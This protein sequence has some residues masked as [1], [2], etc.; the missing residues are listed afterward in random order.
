LLPI[1]SK[2]KSLA[3]LLEQSPLSLSRNAAAKGPLNK[4]LRARLEKWAEAV[5]QL[6]SELSSWAAALIGGSPAE[7]APSLLH[8]VE[9][10]WLNT[11][12]SLYQQIYAPARHALL[13]ASGKESEPPY[14]GLEQPFYADYLRP[15]LEREQT[16]ESLI[17][18]LAARVRWLCRAESKGVRLQLFVAEA[19]YG[20]DDAALPRML[21]GSSQ[22]LEAYRKLCG[23]A[24]YYSARLEERKEIDPAQVGDFFE[25]QPAFLAF[26]SSRAQTTLAGRS[27]DKHYL[28]I[29]KLEWQKDLRQPQNLKPDFIQRGAASNPARA[30]TWLSMRHKIFLAGAEVYKRAEESYSFEPE[31]HIFFPEQRA[32]YAESRLNNRSTHNIEARQYLHPRFIR[33]LEFGE[34]VS[35]SGVEKRVTLADVFL[36]GWLCRLIESD[37]RMQRWRIPP[38]GKFEALEFESKQRSL[39]DAL[40]QFALEIP[41]ASHHTVA[42]PLAENNR[43]AY[44]A[45][46]AEAMRKKIETDRAAWSERLREVKENVIPQITQENDVRAKSLAIY[47]Q[48]L[49][50]EERRGGL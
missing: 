12:T 33:L 43:P 39:L 7:S 50:V 45:A 47:L 32:A 2:V 38:A 8:I 17:S 40:E 11:R 15:E 10:E 31:T 48:F 36:R 37:E 49:V 25:G 26:S 22:W 13:E 9:S 1:L 4:N 5:A 19:E 6:E 27:E 24:E 29:P 3:K 44:V 14:P 30:I 20:D 46:L 18:K 28:L 41:C 42:D 21:Y 16:G 34:T 35:L 23:L